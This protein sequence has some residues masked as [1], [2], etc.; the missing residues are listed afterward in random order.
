MTDPFLA[1]NTA[2]I[3]AEQARQR[4]LILATACMAGLLLIIAN[5]ALRLAL[6][7]PD[8]IAQAVERGA[9]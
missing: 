5:M 7:W 9:M 8:M 3:R 1:Q 6:A 2:Q 4:R